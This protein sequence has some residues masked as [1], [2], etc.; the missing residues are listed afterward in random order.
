MTEA[1]APASQSPVRRRRQVGGAVA[2]AGGTPAVATADTMATQDAPTSV[3]EPPELPEGLLD[4]TTPEDDGEHAPTDG[5]GVSDE[6]RQPPLFAK[7]AE[8]ALTPATPPR[9]RGRP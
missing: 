4:E 2:P 3:S 6:L 7:I 1:A 5:E 8:E 9:R